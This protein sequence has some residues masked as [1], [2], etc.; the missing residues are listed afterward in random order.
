MSVRG[1]GSAPQTTREDMR[2]F[3]GIT[4]P[5]NALVRYV[6]LRHRP[7][8]ARSFDEMKEVTQMALEDLAR[9]MSH[10]LT[11]LSI[12]LDREG[13]QRKLGAKGNGAI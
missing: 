6:I 12:Y 11:E 8:D 1:E 4:D 13:V 3:P 7:I 10:H 2:K 9:Q 5:K